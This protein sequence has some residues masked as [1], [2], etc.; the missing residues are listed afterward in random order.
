MAFTPFILIYFIN[1]QNYVNI[2]SLIITNFIY[3][4]YKNNF[5]YILDIF[6]STIFILN[7]LIKVKK[8]NKII[9]YISLFLI[10]LFFI[11][12]SING[13]NGDR[14]IIYH[15]IFRFIVLILFIKY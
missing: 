13:Q 4:N 11:K 14:Q 12:S 15:L 1:K 3:W 8:K 9:F 2:L 5:T 7:I 10:L 6:F